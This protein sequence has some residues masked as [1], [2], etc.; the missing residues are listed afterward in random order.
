[1]EPGAAV[2]EV[3]DASSRDLRYD[4]V[5]L[6][7]HAG[8]E[9]STPLH[10]EAAARL[11]E[12]SG[13]E[14]ATQT[15][16]SPISHCVKGHGAQEF[17]VHHPV[18]AQAL[19]RRRSMEELAWK[20]PQRDRNTL[21]ED[22]GVFVPEYIVQNTYRSP[23]HALLRPSVE[24]LGPAAE[25]IGDPT[26]VIAAPEHDHA[27]FRE[28]TL[29]RSLDDGMHRP[30]VPR[31]ET[32]S[33]TGHEFDP[34]S[35]RDTY[36]TVVQLVSDLALSNYMSA[37]TLPPTHVAGERRRSRTPHYV[38]PSPVNPGKYSESAEPSS[39][40]SVM[41]IRWDPLLAHHLAREL[42]Q[43]L[44]GARLRAL[45]LDGGARDLTLL[46]RTAT[47]VWRLHPTRG[48]LRLGD[49]V[50]PDASDQRLRARVRSVAAPPDE[51]IVRIELLSE[52]RGPAHLDVVVELLGNQWNAL[53]TE[54]TEGVIR[55]VLKRRERPRR[56][57]VG[58]RYA[59]PTPTGRAGATRDV[60]LG[61]WL[62][63]LREAD[64]ADRPRVL[65][66]TF[67]WTSPLNAPTILGT[68]PDDAAL[69]R[70][71]ERWRAMATGEGV[72][73]VL[74]E[75]EG[76]LQPYPIP[77]HGV[78][79]RRV[80]TLVEAFEECAR[81]AE[82]AGDLPSALTLGPALM[83]GLESAVRQRERRLASLEAELATLEDADALRATGDL[84]LAR[85]AEIPAGAAEVTLTGFDG[86]DVTI[87]LD[88]GSAPHESADSYYA[89]AARAE[90]GRARLP[91]LIDG[92]RSALVEMQDLLSRALEGT[93]EPDEVRAALPETAPA[94][95]THET[96]ASSPY[97]SFRSSGGLE[98][99][100]G[101][102][103][104]HNDA[105]TFKHASPGDIWLHARHAGGAHVVLRWQGKGAPPAKD[106]AEAATLAALYSK[107]RTSGTVPVDWTYRKYVRKPRGSPPG[108]VVPDRVQTLFVEPDERL[109]EKLAEGP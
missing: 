41:A 4:L 54:G 14:C 82:A 58:Q 36:V 44:A 25:Q 51:R 98:I 35:H 53:V 9:R 2:E 64:P 26:H 91:R 46:F 88:P 72:Q 55:H 37:V 50:E 104:R 6:G 77:L 62:R 19:R 65:V 69:E 90:R 15:P 94:H 45:R 67:A 92:A 39:L 103:A 7:G 30:S 17:T 24:R 23:A 95:R 32:R 99:R 11:E 73:P 63:A 108:S 5:E 79:S 27:P 28:D 34:E 105:L 52:R 16:E 47:L 83:T 80:E 8:A 40:L 96:R 1:V 87:A 75:T 12:V 18:H 59:P 101:R 42:D 48:H 68:R 61:T 57:A 76:G 97:R 89:R 86:S 93:A 33:E 74:L 3:C 85:Y 31:R 71:Y 56:L 78:N 102:G 29:G 22:V 84:I 107:G 13:V 20:V 109:L 43:V 100:V 21:P 38:V 10:P 70:A 81:T 49:A 106:L 60:G 66:R